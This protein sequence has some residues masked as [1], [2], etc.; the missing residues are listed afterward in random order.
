MPDAARV[1]KRRARV[2]VP[3]FPRCVSRLDVRRSIGVQHL[4]LERIAGTQAGG[5]DKGCLTRLV[6]SPIGPYKK[7]GQ[8]FGMRRSQARVRGAMVRQ[9]ARERPAAKQR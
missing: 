4:K 9:Q 3:Y 1:P 5:T 8:R 7:Q 6:I 2:T